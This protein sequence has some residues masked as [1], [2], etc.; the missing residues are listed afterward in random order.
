[1]ILTEYFSYSHEI[2]EVLFLEASILLV[3]FVWSM[4]LQWKFQRNFLYIALPVIVLGALINLDLEN[5]NNWNMYEINEFMLLAK[6]I[7]GCFIM[8][9][10]KIAHYQFF[11]SEVGNT[12]LSKPADKTILILYNW[13][14]LC[15][16][17]STKD[18]FLLFLGIEL[19][20]LTSYALIAW[21]KETSPIAIEASIKYLII[22]A[23][24]TSLLLLSIFLIITTFL[25]TNMIDGY[26]QASNLVIEFKGP[27]KK[28]LILLLLSS[29]LL[30]LG[31]SP[32]HMWV[33]DVYEGAPT[34]VTMLLAIPVKLGLFFT[35]IRVLN[36]FFLE[37]YAMKTALIFTAILSLFIGCYGAIYQKKIKRMLAYSSINNLGF[38]L[39]GIASGTLS[40][41]KNAIIYLIFYSLALLLIL[42]MLINKG[43]T[44]KDTF[45][46]V[47][48][49]EELYFN[50]IKNVKNDIVFITDFKELTPLNKGLLTLTLFSL[51]GIP[52]L[53]GFFTKLL[54]FNELINSQLYILLAVAAIAST[55]S[56]YYYINIIKIM[57]FENNLHVANTNLKK[58]LYWDFVIENVYWGFSFIPFKNGHRSFVLNN[59]TLIIFFIL[60][61]LPL[62]LN[63]IENVIEY[64]II[65]L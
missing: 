37:F 13:L 16:I 12:R 43:N 31:A 14:G 63:S 50:K 5:T 62:T 8:Y 28:T 49:S 25:E 51:A 29:F 47:K 61:S 26:Y 15:I 23:F 27:V 35:F 6:I 1:M 48:Y 45:K 30:K 60:M 41:T 55:I 44:E 19:I 18:W 20:A 2:W 11:Y 4:N 56:S 65:T 57:Y 3:I 64:A 59:H 34:P 36:I 58:E 7:I 53:T 17:I 22:G 54:I 42:T 33:A 32:F 24:S 9:I 40:G 46:N 10:I 52:P 21:K 38:A 39:A